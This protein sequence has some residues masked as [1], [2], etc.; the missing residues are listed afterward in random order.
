[1]ITYV[2]KPLLSVNPIVTI[3]IAATGGR[4]QYNSFRILKKKP[5]TFFSIQCSLACEFVVHLGQKLD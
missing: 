5:P 1:M 2:F 4:V 3:I